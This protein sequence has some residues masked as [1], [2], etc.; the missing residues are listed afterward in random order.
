MYAFVEKENI[1]IQPGDRK[2]INTG[3]RISIS[4]SDCYARIAPRSGLAV[5]GIDISAGVVDSDYTG[6]IHVL[7]VNNSKEEFTVKHGDR[8]AQMVFEQ[9]IHPHFVSTTILDSTDRGD[10]GFGSTGV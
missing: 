4:S 3:I 10:K 1:V 6:Y 5:K 7:V 8:I 9:I 2:L